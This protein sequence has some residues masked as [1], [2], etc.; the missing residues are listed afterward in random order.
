MAKKLVNR[1]G[2]HGVLAAVGWGKMGPNR[3]PTENKRVE[4]EKLGFDLSQTNDRAASRIIDRGQW[5]TREVRMTALVAERGLAVGQRVRNKETGSEGLLGY[6]GLRQGI[7]NVK[8]DPIPGA[9]KKPSSTVGLSDLEVVQPD[10][11]P[12]PTGGKDGETQS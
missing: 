10:T 6:I 5:A 11:P 1:G 2:Y 12:A 4:G 8:W 3:P 9:T 7:G